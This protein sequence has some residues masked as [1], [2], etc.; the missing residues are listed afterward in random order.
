MNQFAS[1]KDYSFSAFNAE[2]IDR[3][4]AIT[5]PVRPAQQPD[6]PDYLPPGQ[7]RQGDTNSSYFVKRMISCSTTRT[8]PKFREAACAMRNRSVGI[9]SINPR[10]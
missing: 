10:Q 8:P 7:Q 1:F 2:L 6:T 4:P 5:V 9:G 3:T